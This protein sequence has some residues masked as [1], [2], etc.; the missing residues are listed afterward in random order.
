MVDIDI[1]LPDQVCP[2]AVGS[3]LLWAGDDSFQ[4]EGTV[5]AIDER[6]VTIRV[7]GTGTR[8]VKTFELPACDVWLTG[9]PPFTGSTT[10]IPKAELPLT[11]TGGPTR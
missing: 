3:D 5:T 6:T 9:R 11:H 7:V 10:I 4:T 8:K 2:P 1:D